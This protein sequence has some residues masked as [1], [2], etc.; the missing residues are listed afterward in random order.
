MD[1]TTRKVWGT[2]LGAER[3]GGG[4]RGGAWGGGGGGG[5]ERWKVLQWNISNQ[6]HFSRPL[7]LVPKFPLFGCLDWSGL[8]Y[9][10]VL[11]MGMN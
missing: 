3:V 11:I 1:E 5:E 6:E 8:F 9:M 10:V 2:P 4:V 7:S